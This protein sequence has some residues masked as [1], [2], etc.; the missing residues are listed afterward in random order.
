VWL[1]TLTKSIDADTEYKEDRL[2]RT[3]TAPWTPEPDADLTAH[4]CAETFAA[5]VFVS[6]HL[7]VLG[8]EVTGFVFP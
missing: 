1:A 3:I 2:L 8:L 5:T 6:P 7:H 4:T